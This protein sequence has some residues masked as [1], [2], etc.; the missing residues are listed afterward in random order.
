MIHGF[1]SSPA[2]FQKMAPALADRGFTCRVMRLPGFAEPMEAYTQTSKK[3]WMA[4]IER[5]VEV[6]RREHASVWLMGHSLGASLALQYLLD[7]PDKADGAVVLAP[8][9]GVSN[10]RSPVFASRTWYELGNAFFRHSSVVENHLPPDGEDTG[11]NMQ[12][13]N[14]RFI[15]CIVY[16]EMFALVDDV[17]GR[18]GVFNK[19]LLMVLSKD[20]QVINSRIVEMFFDEAPTSHK[21]LAYIEDSGH[22]IPMDDGWKEVVAITGDFILADNQGKR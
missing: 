6:L 10:Q 3:K 15:P 17:N 22:D 5:E 1:A 8:L 16:R 11:V 20:D 7:Y 13:I 19:P 18:A 12:D 4:A 9:L 21:K 14:D 2:I